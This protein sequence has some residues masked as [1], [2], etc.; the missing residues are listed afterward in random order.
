MSC[1]YKRNLFSI[2]LPSVY[3]LFFSTRSR[4]EFIHHKILHNLPHVKPTDKIECP[5]CKRSYV[6]ASLRCHLRIHTNERLFRCNQCSWSFIRAANLKEHIKNVHERS[7][8]KNM[9]FKCDVCSKDFRLKWVKFI[10]V[11]LKKGS[12]PKSLID[13]RHQKRE[14]YK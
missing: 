4:A 13:N 11:V 3:T 7:L 6:K 8:M 2:S 10:F 9:L 1:I 12:Y 14:K 5:F